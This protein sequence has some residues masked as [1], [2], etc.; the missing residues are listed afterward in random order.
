MDKS[1][2]SLIIICLFFLGIFFLI[3]G[4]GSV[5]NI[6][7]VS[8]ILETKETE[9]V[10]NPDRYGWK[11][12]VSTNKWSKRDS[13][14]EYQFGGKLFILGGLNGEPGIVAHH[15]VVYENVPHYNDIWVSDDGASWTMALE[16]AKFPPVRSAS[17][18]EYGGALYMYG[19]WSPE[20][21]YTLGI[22]KSLDGI[23]WEQI[24]KKP[25]YDERE[26][27]IVRVFK[28]KIYL[29]GGV[30]YGLKK[31]FNDVWESSDGI[32]FKKITDAPWASRW[33]H[34]VAELNGELYLASGMS[35]ATVGYHDLWK[36]SDGINWIE[37]SSST[38]W[39]L[40]QGHG[41]V[42]YKGYLWFVGG[43]NT[44]NDEGRSDTWYS[45]D[46]TN[47][48][49]LPFDGEWTGREDMSVYIF[50]D[51]IYI[52][53]GMG[54]DWRWQD[55]A[56]VLDEISCGDGLQEKIR[57]I[58][59]NYISSDEWA[60]YCLDK[61]GEPFYMAGTNVAHTPHA[62]ASVTKLMTALIASEK[63]KDED[64]IEVKK[65]TIGVGSL[66]RYKVG[67]RFYFYQA[68]SSLLLESDNDIARS[69][70][71]FVG[72]NYFLELMNNKAREIGMKDTT[73]KNSSGLDLSVQ[74]QSNTSS[75]YDLAKLVTYILKNKSL[76]FD[77]GKKNFM[78]VKDIS[79]KTHHIA[80]STNELLKDLEVKDFI[81]GAK[82][83]ETPLAK[84]NLVTVFKDIGGNKFIS[85]VLG[86]ADHF[87]DTKKIMGLVLQK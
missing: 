2:S 81:V 18:V 73:F 48:N 76:I 6:G 20:I 1:K 19:G 58:D 87:S 40:K 55:D 63:I 51:K 46:G 74:I 45:K 43:L 82:T 56:W 84:K 7:Y 11:E 77:I 13:H 37:V 22:W 44:S 38:P 14:T 53:G 42:N 49:K 5:F 78:E 16:H 9:K 52:N 28:G 41:L 85:I 70:S 68:L 17:V 61:T 66:N 29:I 47:W 80:N 12:V 67:E 31:T 36:S 32:N 54:A 25:D 35:S 62:I 75:P 23:N 69:I 4:V 72:D 30:N 21:G 15:T 34:D 59:K 33:D 50:K 39:G 26:G 65:E 8:N 79:G 71:Y 3:I 57:S 64:V 24:L 83:G 10:F 86:S 27:Q 60:L